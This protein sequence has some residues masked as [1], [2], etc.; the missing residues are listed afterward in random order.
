MPTRLLCVKHPIAI[1]SLLC[2]NLMKVCQFKTSGGLVLCFPTSNNLVYFTVCILLQEA[3]EELVF[4]MSQM[5]SAELCF[6]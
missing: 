1:K 6:V 3:S 2:R 5:D 4:V